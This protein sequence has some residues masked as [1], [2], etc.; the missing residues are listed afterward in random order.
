MRQP[1]LRTPLDY[2]IKGLVKGGIGKYHRKPQ[3][4]S[5]IAFLDFL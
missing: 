4:S 1:D 2:D 3:P 5:I